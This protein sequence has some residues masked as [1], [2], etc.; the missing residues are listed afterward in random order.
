MPTAHITPLPTDQ[1]AY[2]FRQYSG[3]HDSQDTFLR[4]DLR[5][6]EVT[7]DYNPEIG[8]SV[9]AS[10]YHNLVLRFDIPRLA[11]LFANDLL[12]EALPIAQRILDGSSIGL[13]HLRSN[14]VGRLDA[15]AE[16]AS[17]ELVKLIAA[18]DD[19]RFSIGVL[20]AA[21]WFS[22]AALPP[23]TADTTDAE[24][25]ALAAAQDAEA[26]TCTDAEVTVLTGTLEFLTELRDRARDEVREKLE[27]VAE[28]YGELRDRRDNMI[29][30]IHR[31]N[32]RGDTLR[33]IGNL[34]DISHTR[35]DQI[36]RS[37]T[38][39]LPAAGGGPGGAGYAPMTL[40]GH[41]RRGD[42]ACYS[43]CPHDSHLRNQS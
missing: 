27:E 41:L 42:G 25:E 29:R 8:N 1:P 16:Q 17:D 38:V 18:Y 9:P 2:L 39:V 11:T 24:L 35:V 19:D 21:E 40:A 6:G 13:D 10:V 33:S 34:A 14:E 22:V 30:Q 36:I 20:A 15:S 5:D 43:S 37:G 26:L 12:T 32:E 3:Q 23:V 28:Q 31:W 7:C 4:I